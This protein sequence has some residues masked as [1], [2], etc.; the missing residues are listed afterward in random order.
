MGGRERGQTG[1]LSLQVRLAQPGT[2]LFIS[3]PELFTSNYFTTL[4]SLCPGTPATLK[5]KNYQLTPQQG[6]G[7]IGGFGQSWATSSGSSFWSPGRAGKCCAS[8]SP[9]LRMPCTMPLVNSA[10]RK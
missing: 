4:D 10:R 6:E 7:A 2:H 3:E 1:G 5:T 8:S 9:A